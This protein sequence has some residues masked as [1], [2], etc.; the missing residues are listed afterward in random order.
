ME[1]ALLSLRN[2]FP[3]TP[4][5]FH[6]LVK[7]KLKDRLTCTLPDFRS[8]LVH[9]RNDSEKTKDITDGGYVKWVVYLVGPQTTMGRG[10]FH[11]WWAA[12]A[13]LTTA[14]IAL[15]PLLFP[16]GPLQRKEWRP[17]K[18]WIILFVGLPEKKIFLSALRENSYMTVK[19][20]KR[21]ELHNVFPQSCCMPFAHCQ[22]RKI[23]FSFWFQRICFSVTITN[24]AF[25][26]LSPPF[27]AV[28]CHR[29]VSWIQEEK[30]PSLALKIEALCHRHEKKTFVQMH[31]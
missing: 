1:F 24:K 28:D 14:A 21:G 8:R 18:S 15:L 25:L 27:F 26:L 5:T 20:K 19:C 9:S 29:Q 3:R 16:N 11:S 22:K 2:N 6:G 7:I 23:R 30:R 12:G 13:R 17:P 31:V 10:C 4:A